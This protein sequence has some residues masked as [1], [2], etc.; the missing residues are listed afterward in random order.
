[1]ERIP[2]RGVKTL[3]ELTTPVVDKSR[4]KKLLEEIQDDFVPEEGE[5]EQ[6]DPVE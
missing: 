5:K 6:S 4:R 2:Q 3:E 1:M